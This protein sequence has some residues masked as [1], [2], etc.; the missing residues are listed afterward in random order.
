MYTRMIKKRY[1]N[2]RSYVREDMVGHVLVY[3]LLQRVR[4]HF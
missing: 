1:K 4:H 3:I 2:Q